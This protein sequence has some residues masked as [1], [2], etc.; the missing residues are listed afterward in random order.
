MCVST[1]LRKAHFQGEEKMNSQEL[2]DANGVGR[3]DVYT[4]VTKRI[5]SD[6]EKGIRPWVKP[7]NAEYAS[8]RN[9]T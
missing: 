7:W 6:L 1:A 2:A 5:I 3:K 9:R 4:K 8:G